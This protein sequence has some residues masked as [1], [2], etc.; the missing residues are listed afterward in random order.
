MQK[1]RKMCRIRAGVFAEICR[2]AKEDTGHY[3]YREDL[4]GGFLR[5]LRI[6]SRDGPW[7]SAIG[8]VVLRD[9]CLNGTK[10]RKG[11]HICLRKVFLK[12]ISHI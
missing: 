4:I 6:L 11:D 5:L 3:R 1:K 7:V 9:I 8:V 10:I 12:S 2:I